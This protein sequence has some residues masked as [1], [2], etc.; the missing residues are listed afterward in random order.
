M[1]FY[2]WLI[3]NDYILNLKKKYILQKKNL[4]CVYFESLNNI[5]CRLFVFVFFCNIFLLFIIL[6]EIFFIS[7]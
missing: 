1:I 6:I 3:L 7:M 2:I 5:T 4:T